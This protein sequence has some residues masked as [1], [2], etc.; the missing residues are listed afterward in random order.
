M[1]KINYFQLLLTIILSSLISI[2]FV[3]YTYDKLENQLES[4]IILTQNEFVI[5]DYNEQYFNF[6]RTI[7]NTID[8]I[9][10]FPALECNFI[11]DVSPR[12]ISM[13]ANRGIYII[14]IFNPNKS[15]NENC[16]NY[17]LDLI[18][19]EFIKNIQKKIDQLNTL[20]S[21]RLKALDD[22]DSEKITLEAQRKEKMIKLEEFKFETKKI[23]FSDFLELVRNNKVLE[24]GI[25]E[26]FITGLTTSSEKFYTVSKDL[27]NSDFL[28]EFFFEKGLDFY[29]IDED[30]SKNKV[31]REVYNRQTIEDQVKLSFY[32]NKINQSP[33]I[34]TE[35]NH[36]DIRLGFKIYTLIILI[37]FNIVG[38]I[39]FIFI[40]RTYL[41]PLFNFLKKIS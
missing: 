34:I 1:K 32:K 17:I 23:I 18:K 8:K 39:I 10:L 41:K 36:K 13:T 5:G 26:D 2:F 15:D 6:D 35:V 21:L 28:I 31:Y 30:Y 19:L 25:T 29:F 11:K 40:N 16:F 38:I 20:Q 14:K 37:L 22:L 4:K 33:I 3:N 7:F 27:S 24:I 9:R 12:P